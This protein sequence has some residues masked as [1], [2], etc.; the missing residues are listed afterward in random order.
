MLL[1]II[2]GLDRALLNLLDQ[3]SANYSSWAKSG[4]P[5][6]FVIKV[7]LERIHIYLFTYC[8]WLLSCYSE[9]GQKEKQIPY[10]NTYIWNLKKK[11]KVLMNLGAGQD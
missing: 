7:L 2:A 11:K 9:V 5:L 1:E 8:L 10:A 3:G 6:V 4:P